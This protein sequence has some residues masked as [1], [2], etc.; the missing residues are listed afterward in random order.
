MAGEEFVRT[1]EKADYARPYAV[2]ELRA[3]MERGN[4]V[5]DTLGTEAPAEV[6]LSMK[7]VA[8]AFDKRRTLY[9]NRGY[10]I[11]TVTPEENAVLAAV[12]V[13]VADS[14]QRAHDYLVARC[15][16]AL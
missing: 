9:A 12:E 16:I 7:A 2:E 5:T 8:A 11:A 3:F 1:Y 13:D 15:N 14:K 10:D 4:V 6:E